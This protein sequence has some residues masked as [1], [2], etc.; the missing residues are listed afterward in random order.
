MVAGEAC[1]KYV[2]IAYPAGSI[3]LVYLPSKLVDSHGRLVGKV[4]QKSH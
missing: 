2:M 3:G 1:W 4:I